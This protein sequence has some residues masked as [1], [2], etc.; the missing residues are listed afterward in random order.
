M[1]ISCP[2]ENVSSL[3]NE[4][5]IVSNKQKFSRL[6]TTLSTHISKAVFC[7]RGTNVKLVTISFKC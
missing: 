1:L 6:F 7:F 2:L 3:R 5:Y 4:I